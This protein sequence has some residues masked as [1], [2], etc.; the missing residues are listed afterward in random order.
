MFTEE[1]LAKK[2]YQNTNKKGG[3]T[4]IFLCT[5]D[6]GGHAMWIF[7]GLVVSF[8]LGFGIGKQYAVNKA[9]QRPSI[10][11][12]RDVECRNEA[13]VKNTPDGYAV[14]NSYVPSGE[15]E[16]AA[17]QN[18]SPVEMVSTPDKM[19]VVL[20]QDD[21][22]YFLQETD[23]S[24]GVGSRPRFGILKKIGHSIRRNLF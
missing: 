2:Y 19:F 14:M 13:V 21:G 10:I 16:N 4:A 7:I 9:A 1:Q 18:F 22:V 6:T 11:L 23:D 3:S 15:E 5:A 20:G 12:Y 17:L 24:K 8:G